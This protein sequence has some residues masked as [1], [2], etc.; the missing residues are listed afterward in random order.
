LCGHLIIIR[1]NPIRSLLQSA[2]WTHSQ[3][4]C[5]NKLTDFKFGNREEWDEFERSLCTTEWEHPAAYLLS[6]LNDVEMEEDT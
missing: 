4:T 1:F 5:Q 6:E 3:R 2:E